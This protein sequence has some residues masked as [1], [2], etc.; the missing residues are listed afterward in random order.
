MTSSTTHLPQ[1]MVDMITAH[2]TTPDISRLSR[3]CKLLRAATL[4][5]LYEEVSMCWT[6]R[7]LK[8]DTEERSYAPRL[9][10]LLRTLLEVPDLA[11]SVSS[12][13]LQAVSV[14]SPSATQIQLFEAAS[15]QMRL[16]QSDLWRTAIREGYAGPLICLLLA[17]CTRLRFLSLG[18]KFVRDSIFLPGFLAALARVSP[19]SEWRCFQ[20][21]RKLHLGNPVK[22][23]A[24]LPGPVWRSIL[25]KSYLVFLQAPALED[26]KMTP[27]WAK[28]GF[29]KLSIMPHLIRLS[30]FNSTAPPK[31]LGEMLRFTPALVELSY[32]HWIY[33]PHEGVNGN[34]LQDALEPVRARL[35]SFELTCDYYTDGIIDPWDCHGVILVGSCSFR[36]FNALKSLC[37]PICALFGWSSRNAPAFSA[38]LPP[39]LVTLHLGFDFW[40]YEDF[41]WQA[42]VLLNHAK[43]FLQGERW[44]E[45]TPQLTQLNLVYDPDFYFDEE[46][47]KEEFLKVCSEFESLCTSNGISCI[48]GTDV[49]FLR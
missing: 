1:E 15:R 39:S 5:S 49:E 46:E 21:L 8:E 4:P 6:Y 16:P 24:K 7:G 31:F 22:F 29:P 44:R 2:L 47:E 27:P 10:L 25:H 28:G 11:K 34:D 20:H 17:T 35:T 41:E 18:P 30:L 43:G 40:L 23:E 19:S 48:V 3:T 13:D 33:C 14:P 12:I 38:V 36:H 37:V 26:A 9:D 45:T 42:P 32:R